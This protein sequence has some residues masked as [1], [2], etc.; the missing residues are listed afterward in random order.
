MRKNGKLSL[1]KNNKRIRLLPLRLK[2][3]YL[4]ET[5]LHNNTIYDKLK[6]KQFQNKLKD[7]RDYVF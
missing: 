5:A 6:K 7:V 2:C 4:N 3:I 1:H